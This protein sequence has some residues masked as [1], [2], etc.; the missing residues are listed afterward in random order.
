V[1]LSFSEHKGLKSNIDSSFFKNKK[2]NEFKKKK[3][4]LWWYVSEQK[5]FW[6][7]IPKQ[8]PIPVRFCYCSCSVFKFRPQKKVT[9]IN[10][11]SDSTLFT[12]KLTW[13]PGLVYENAILKLE[14]MLMDS[15]LTSLWEYAH[16]IPPQHIACLPVLSLVSPW[17]PWTVCVKWSGRGGK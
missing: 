9:W 3:K 5:T 4:T 8:A 13:N 1:D 15:I 2:H 12:D 7:S 14:D 6:I 16:P 10:I 17:A 11:Q